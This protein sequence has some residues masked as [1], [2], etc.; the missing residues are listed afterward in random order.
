MNGSCIAAGLGAVLA[1]FAGERAPEA[2]ATERRGRA[3]LHA[4][5]RDRQGELPSK[6]GGDASGAGLQHRHECWGWVD[7]AV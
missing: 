4:R 6:S 1:A 5:Q 3:G 7:G 2:N